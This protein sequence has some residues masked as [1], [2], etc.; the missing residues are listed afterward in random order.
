MDIVKEINE[1]WEPSLYFAKLIPIIIASVILI[2]LIIKIISEIRRNKKQDKEGLFA[3]IAWALMVYSVIIVVITI[4]MYMFL[5]QNARHTGVKVEGQAVLE[6]YEDEGEG[7]VMAKLKGKDNQEINIYLDSS[8]VLN[9]KEKISRGDKVRIK[10][11]K[12]Y[13]LIKRE[14]IISFSNDDDREYVLKDGAELERVE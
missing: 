7:K 2:I 12:A 10:S 1:Y 13:A 3:K 4:P 5:K 8:D 6:K 11:D 9:Q 14:A